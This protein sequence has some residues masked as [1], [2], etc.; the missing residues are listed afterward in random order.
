MEERLV[1]RLRVGV[2]KANAKTTGNTSI[3]LEIY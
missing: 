1:G 3:R 2:Y